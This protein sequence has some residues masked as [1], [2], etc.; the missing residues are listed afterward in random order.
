MLSTSNGR[1][2]GLDCNGSSLLFGF[3]LVYNLLCGLGITDI[4]WKQMEA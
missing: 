4:L 2:V 1:G 3:D